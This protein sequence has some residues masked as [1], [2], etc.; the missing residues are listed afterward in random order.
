MSLPD[1]YTSF[2]QTLANVLVTMK[3]YPD[4][5]SKLIPFVVTVLVPFVPK[6]PNLDFTIGEGITQ[7]AFDPF[8]INPVD[9]DAGENFVEAYIYIGLELTT[10]IDFSTDLFRPA[11]SYEWL[12]MNY[13]LNKVSVFTTVGTYAGYYTVYLI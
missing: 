8:V 11:S 1:D 10:K 9:F 2:G 12:H 13:N 4:V 3:L 7:F 5:V 6:I